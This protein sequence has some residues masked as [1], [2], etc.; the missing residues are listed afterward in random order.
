MRGGAR[1]APAR[2]SSSP[3]RSPT[4]AC[5]RTPSPTRQRAAPQGA[6]TT[7]Y[8]IPE[9]AGSHDFKFGYHYLRDSARR[10]ANAGA[11]P[12]RYRDFEG[13]PFEVLLVDVPSLDIL[14]AQTVT[15]ALPNNIDAHNDFFVQDTWTPHQRLT[16]NIGEDAQALPRVKLQRLT[17]VFVN[18]YRFEKLLTIP[19]INRQRIFPLRLSWHDN[20][21]RK[22]RQLPEGSKIRL[23][24]PQEDYSNFGKSSVEHLQDFV[25][26][27]LD[28]ESVPWGQLSQVLSAKEECSLIIVSLNLSRPSLRSC[29][30][31]TI[32][33]GPSSFWSRC[34]G[35]CRTATRRSPC[36]AKPTFDGETMVGLLKF[37]R[38]PFLFAPSAPAC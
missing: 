21:I 3:G 15:S 14:P 12:I 37:W 19:G 28:I 7:N 29:W 35:S 8:Y 9:A 26:N 34:I 38:R 10:G 25:G 5:D 13:V 31:R 20:I 23:V 33:S 6:I 18:S 16:L 27:A 17:A 24:L 4:G 36:S 2:A 11:G 22:L 1:A 32:S 30:K